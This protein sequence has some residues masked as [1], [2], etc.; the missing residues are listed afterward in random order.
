MLPAS[1]LRH[2]DVKSK[3]GTVQAYRRGSN[4]RHEKSN[5]FD[6][7][8]PHRFASGAKNSSAFSITNSG[9]SSGMK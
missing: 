2:L 7:P 3:S 8:D 1:L 4:G 6:S 5:R 9:F